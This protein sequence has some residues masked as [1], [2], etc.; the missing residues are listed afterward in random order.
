LLLSEVIVRIIA[1][2]NHHRRV[3]GDYTEDGKYNQGY[4]E[5]GWDK[6]KGPF[7]DVC[8]HRAP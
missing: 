2:E 4:Q 5:Q 1:A 6:K 7:D 8:P 3:T